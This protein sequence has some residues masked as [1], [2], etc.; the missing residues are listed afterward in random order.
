MGIDDLKKYADKAKDAVSEHRE[1]IEDKAG[2][3]IDKA[4][5]GDN[6]EKAKN[7]LHSGLDKLS[8]K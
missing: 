6:A 2:D 5:K 8:G 3:V 1:T 7:A 4:I